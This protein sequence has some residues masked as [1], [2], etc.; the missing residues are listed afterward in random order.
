MNGRKCAASSD[1][2]PMSSVSPPEERI[3]SIFWH[4]SMLLGRAATAVRWLRVDF[5]QELAGRI[6]PAG[7]G[8]AAGR[9]Q[10]FFR[11]RIQAAF[12]G[13]FDAD[14]G[15]RPAAVNS[16][17]A[18][19]RQFI[20]RLS[21]DQLGNA[22]WRATSVCAHVLREAEAATR[23]NPAARADFEE[24]RRH[25]ERDFATLSDRTRSVVDTMFSGLVSPFLTRPLRP[26]FCEDTTVRVEQ[27][28]EGKLLLIDVPVQEYGVVG[29]LCAQIYKRC[30][31]LAILRRSG[32][33]VAFVRRLFSPTK[34]KCS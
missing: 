9:R 11:G 22:Q 34:G 26:L 28:F 5:L 21:L 27:C 7:A 10:R 19:D 32:P 23:D 3:D 1:A 18:R 13:A 17:A 20:A 30:L 2:P 24:C 25:V 15:V 8:T 4:G 31:Q 29:R 6:D 12:A 16:A 14:S 33:P